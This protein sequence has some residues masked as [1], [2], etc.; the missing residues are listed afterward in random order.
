MFQFCWTQ[1]SLY[2]LHFL[3]RSSHSQKKERDIS[4]FD[5]NQVVILCTLRSYCSLGASTRPTVGNAELFAW[6]T[7]R[8]RNV[9]CI[10]LVLN[11]SHRHKICPH[12]DS[13]WS[14]SVLHMWGTACKG[15]IMHHQYIEMV[16]KV[17]VWL[18]KR[19]AR[20]ASTSPS[21]I[22]SISFL[23]RDLDNCEFIGSCFD[24]KDPVS[25][26]KSRRSICR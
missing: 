6:V 17:M 19:T 11:C 20:T 10:G 2:I 4:T 12:L 8:S 22:G 1:I 26:C 13:A 24:H 3:K 21:E 18:T 23:M 14:S 15:S 16:V 5:E 25:I 9:Q 7:R